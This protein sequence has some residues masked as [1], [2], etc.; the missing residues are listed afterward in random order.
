MRIGQSDYVSEEGG[1]CLIRVESTTV[2]A[3]DFQFRLLPR[4]VDM[5]QDGSLDLNRA[6][7]EF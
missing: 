1:N 2:R 3:D 5:S 6:R 7:G 4:V